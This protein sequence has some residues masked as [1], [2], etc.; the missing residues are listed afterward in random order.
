MFT[1]EKAPTGVTSCSGCKQIIPIRETR[2][3]IHAWSNTYFCKE[4]AMKYLEAGLISLQN[5]EHPHWLFM[6]AVD[7]ILEEAGVIV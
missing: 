5:D 6:E 4:C 1:I 3:T 2:L 7:Q